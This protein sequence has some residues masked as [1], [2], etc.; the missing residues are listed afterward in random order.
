MERCILCGRK[1]S[2]TE[3]NFGIGCLRKVC[4]S[5]EM[6]GIKSLSGQTELDRNIMKLCNKPRLP[7]PQ[8]D[9][10]T[11]RYLTLKILNEVPLEEYDNYKSLL[12]QDINKI[13]KST[14]VE[15][16]ESFKQI[17]LKQAN[18]ISKQYKKHENFFEKMMNGDYDVLQN[19]SFDIVR[20]SFSKYYSNKPYLNETTQRSQY[21]IWKVLAMSFKAIG[22]TF[23]GKCLENSL[24]RSPK[25]MEI[26][27]GSIVNKIK[28]DKKFIDKINVIIRENSQKTK[29][30]VKDKVRFDDGDLLLALHKVTLNV[31][32]EKQT[33]NTW[34]LQIE[35]TDK[36]DFTDY[37]EINEIIGG[38]IG[39]LER[40]GNIANN[41]AMI[42][43]SCN[44]IR[45]Y[46]IS[47]KFNMDNWEVK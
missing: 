38:N 1:I 12:Q 39:L 41:I 40:L 30:I 10:L 27:S 37:K 29:F 26:T 4:L 2:N 28:R 42:S 20:F 47:I 16:L 6:D 11:D 45:E 35:L 32:G 17:S 14:K 8:S 19:L 31:I 36:Y 21:F 44:V 25:D 24:K 23:S 5:M 7:R 34:N 3:Y 33:N 13:E 15:E 22:F 18:E 43:T 9:M 46:D